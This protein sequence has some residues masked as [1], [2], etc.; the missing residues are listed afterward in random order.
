FECAGAYYPDLNEIETIA[1]GQFCEHFIISNSTFGWWIAWLGEKENSIV[2]HPGHL[3]IGRLAE[4]NDAKDFWPERWVRNQKESYTLDIQ[5]ITFTIPVFFDNKDRKQNL[6]LIV[7]ML[8]SSF[9]TNIIVG[10]QGGN[11]LQYMSQW[12][13]YT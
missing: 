8:Q 9:K 12:C 1:A 6:D 4:E 10:E 5:D 7:C 3:F 13:Q 11:R 2:I